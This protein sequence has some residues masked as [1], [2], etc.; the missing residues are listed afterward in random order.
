M[1]VICDVL[2]KG[3]QE[4]VHV[5]YDSARYT[6]VHRMNPCVHHI[7]GPVRDPC[8]HL[9]GLGT[10]VRSFVLGPCW[11]IVLVWVQY[12]A[13]IGNQQ[14]C[15]PVRPTQ[16]PLTTVYVPCMGET[17]YRAHEPVSER[18]TCTSFTYRG[19]AGPLRV[20]KSAKTRT[21][22]ALRAY[23]ARC[24]VPVRNPGILALTERYM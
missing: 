14:T 15:G 22:Y 2:G 21:V 6:W 4:P 16:G 5:P 1:R 10:P 18:C 23:S 20:E 19:Y 13:N 3:S 11:S 7:Y 8:V 17:S 24:A 9:T 12:G